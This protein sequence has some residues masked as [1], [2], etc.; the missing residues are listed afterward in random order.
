MENK[1]QELTSKIYEEGVAKAREEADK[2]LE[3]ANKEAEETRSK[4]KKEAQ[5]IM[6]QTEREANELKRN[7]ESEIKLV[8]RQSL[9]SIKQQIVALITLKATEEPVKKAFEDKD[10]LKK[11]I[12]TTIKNWNPDQDSFD[13]QLLLPKDEEKSLGEYFASR[14][15]ELLKGGLDIRFDERMRSGFKI[16]PADGRFLISFTDED[17]HNFFKNYLRPRTTELL[18][19][20]E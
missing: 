6:E 9:A 7:T 8:A 14:Q 20:G 10:F 4:A 2:I 12:E 18:F 19:G 17:F 11:I 5:Q 13:L 3:E 16:G 15:K 1:L